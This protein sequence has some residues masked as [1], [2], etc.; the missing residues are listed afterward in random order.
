MHRIKT[1]V[2]SLAD[3]VLVGKLHVRD[4][5][6]PLILALVDGDRKNLRNGVVDKFGAAVA[7]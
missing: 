4:T 7:L 6:V 1:Q 2:R 5:H 3:G